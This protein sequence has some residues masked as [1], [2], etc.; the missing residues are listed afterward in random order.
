MPDTHAALRNNVHLLGEL[1]GNTIKEHL[2]EQ[3]LDKIELIRQLAKASRAGSKAGL[4]ALLTELKGLTDDELLPVTRAFNQF[5]NLANIAEQY[6]TISKHSQQCPLELNPIA[7]LLD[8]LLAR[9]FSADTIIENLSKLKIEL[10]LTAHPTEVTRRT[11]IKKYEEIANCLYVKD[12]HYLSGAE[13]EQLIHRLQQ[14]VS[15]A[16]HTNEIREERPTPV[17]EARWGFATIE[18]S[19]W[20]AV[21]RFLRQLNQ[22]LKQRI[23]RELPLDISPIRFASWM[24]GDRDG[25][26]NVTAAITHQV[27]MLS[28]WMAADL[29]LRDMDTLIGELSMNECNQHLLMEVGNQSEPYR[30]LLKR[31]QTRLRVTRDWAESAARNDIEPTADVLLYKED[32]LAP[33]KL[34]YQSLQDCG[35]H[36]IANGPLLDTLYRAHCFGLNLIKLDIRQDSSRHSDVIAELTNYL[37]LGDYTAWTEEQK[38]A[39]LLKELASKRPLLPCQ[40]QP[41]ADVKEIIDTCRVLSRHEPHAIGSYIISMAKQPSD[42]LAVI[43]LLKECGVQHRVPVVPLFETLNDLANADEVIKNLLGVSWYRDYIQGSQEVM[44]G[45]S[46]SAKDAGMLMA[47]WAQYQAQE[48]LVDICKRA[49]VKLTLFHGRGGSI[50]RGGGPA[51]AAILSQ[52]P[53]SIGERMRITEQGEMIRFKFGLPNVAVRSLALYTNAA[54]EAKLIPPPVPK[55]S[56]RKM[57]DGLTETSLDAYSAVVKEN[58]DFV[59]YFRAATPEQEL[60]KLPLGSRPAKRRSSGGLES[61]RAIPWIFAWTQNR[62]ML[63]SW[64]GSGEALQQALDNKQEPLIREMMSEWPFFRARVNMLEMVLAKADLSLAAYYEQRLV[65]ESL[66]PLG[67]ELRYRLAS[68]VEVVRYL[69]NVHDLLSDEPWIQQSIALRNPYTDPLNV[70]QAELLFRL[71]HETENIKPFVPQALMVTI[72]GIAAGMRNTG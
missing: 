50:G 19:L 16:W 5:L 60:A 27:L 26:P 57:M 23:N 68:T 20:H 41:S 34:C 66:Q 40:W 32:L 30:A 11:L 10:V 56:W 28:R 13:E 9:Q 36:V 52:P 70:L 55:D 44:I 6:H 42:V 43:L 72:A 61:L 35:M 47:S 64:L 38:Q 58:T 49:G 59:A 3:F 25:N 1:L 2:G 4:E 31:L 48:K 46:D 12:H 69:K 15:Q 53:G 33:L 22:Q 21:P 63:P 51:H 14:L 29:Y 45:Y 8:Q 7:E 24:G 62:L 39:F 65:P 18:Y 71:R 67:E 37:E 54:L 17:D